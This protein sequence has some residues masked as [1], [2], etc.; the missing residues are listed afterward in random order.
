MLLILLLSNHASKHGT[1]FNILSE[2]R[3][4]MLL[5]HFNCRVLKQTNL[6]YKRTQAAI[7]N[8]FWNRK[9][10]INNTKILFRS[11]SIY[12]SLYL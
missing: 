6:V 12:C 2:R 10:K 7:L 11:F 3:A 1:I 4:P 5:V 9:I 8:H